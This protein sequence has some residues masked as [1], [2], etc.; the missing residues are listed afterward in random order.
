VDRGSSGGDELAPGSYLAELLRTLW[1]A[2]AH[3]S[4]IPRFAARDR[5]ATEF[6]VV[7]SLRSPKLVLPRRP[8]KVTGAAL[9]N[10]KAS[11]S[12]GARLRLR[13]I[14]LGARLG[15]T[16]LL[17]DRI[18]IEPGPASDTL[19]DHLR[20]TLGKDFHIALYIGPQRAVQ[21]PVLQLLDRAGET[22]AFVKVGTNALTRVLVGN[23]AEALRYLT[24]APLNHLRVPRPMYDGQWNGHRVL[25]QEALHPAGRA[26][27]PDRLARAMV[28]LAASKGTT[29]SRLGDSPY[30]AELRRR[31]AA[32]PR[33]ELTEG[34]ASRLQSLVEHRGNE[35]LEF[36]SWH[37]DF[38]PWN[39]ATTPDSVLVWDWE[40][41]ESGVPVGFDAVHYRVQTGVVMEG[42]TVAEAFE[43][44][45][46]GA[47]ELLAP[48]GVNA[49]RSRLTVA[50]YAVE[51]ATRYVH[52][53]EL[54]SGTVMGRMDRWLTPVLDDLLGRLVVP[55][56]A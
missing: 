50:L 31:I 26:V 25:V 17:P 34:L 24:A 15:A 21:K 48:F 1:P 40:Q 49:A 10:Y 45:L 19:A 7:P 55:E 5:S 42:R 36:G 13:A 6:V 28:E 35:T 4:R 8:R 52:D 16:V 32:E 22:F 18:R 51:I 54:E 29:S 39:M 20:E 3:I 23:E 30:L 44:A 41:Y 11:A 43:V 2:P 33:D 12:G 9:G 14:A 38:A 37:G 27:N 46:G 53:G 47:T 56:R